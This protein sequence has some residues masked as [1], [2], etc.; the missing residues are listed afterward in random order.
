MEREFMQ[1]LPLEVIVK[2]KNGEHR[3]G[4]DDTVFN[5]SVRDFILYLRNSHEFYD[6]PT[7]EMMKKVLI[8]FLSEHISDCRQDAMWYIE[9]AMPLF[10]EKDLKK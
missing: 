5:L 4:D 9:Y 8:K 1:D 3:I 10:L 6:N 7:E 2:D